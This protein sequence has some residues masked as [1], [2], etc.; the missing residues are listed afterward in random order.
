MLEHMRSTYADFVVRNTG[1]ANDDSEH[2]PVILF[3][4][5]PCR[6]DKNTLR[7]VTGTT[8]SVSSAAASLFDVT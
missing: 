8:H 1:N 5:A 7:S 3:P 4:L 2:H 6:R